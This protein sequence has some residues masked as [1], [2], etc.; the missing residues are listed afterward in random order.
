MAKIESK[1]KSTCDVGL[2]EDGTVILQFGQLVKHMTFTPEQAIGLGVGF[3]QMGTRGESLQRVQPP[4]R[5]AVGPGR[6]Q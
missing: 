2:L 3:I 4:G 5:T 6:K 1:G